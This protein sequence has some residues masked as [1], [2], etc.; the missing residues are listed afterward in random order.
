MIFRL[1]V[2]VVHTVYRKR[3]LAME[4]NQIKYFVALARTLHFTRAADLCNVSQPALTR[5]IQKL[6]DELGGPLFLRE[7][8]N[9]QL[10]ELGQTVLPSLDK[11]L[12]AATEAK[13]QAEAFRRRETSPLR[14]GLEFSI[15]AAVL[16]P[17]MVSLRGRNTDI[18]LTL[19]SASQAD[20][21][22]KILAGEIDVA[23]FVD[24]PDL[25]ERLHR[26]RLYAEQYIVICQNDH[27]FRD[28]ATVAPPA[29]AEECLLL[30]ENAACPVRKF[31]AGLCEDAGV[32][33]RRQHFADSSE[34][35][36]EMVQASLGVSVY[37]DRQPALAGFLRRPIEGRGSERTVVL[38]AAA[39]R[40][41]GPT[42]SMFL[43]LMRARP[44]GQDAANARAAQP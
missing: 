41:L 16:T 26:W 10:T 35:I 43:K 30:Y 19:R 20:L 18:E 8:A 14:I 5:A 7:R 3:G 24:G 38:A 27:R 36:M 23:L 15:P 28:H 44:W 34:Q 9:T 4:L 37:G 6:E 39:G 17:V 33:P 12:S 21:C 25:P 1:R 42:P 11:A 2:R 31:V 22:D 40:Q 32:Q 29:L 13:A